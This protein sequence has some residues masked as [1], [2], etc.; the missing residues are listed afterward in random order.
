M[1]WAI[2][3]WVAVSDERLVLHAGGRGEADALHV[4]RQVRAA[5]PNDALRAPPRARPDAACWVVE[6]FVPR[7]VKV[8]PWPAGTAVMVLLGSLTAPAS[9]TS[10]R[11]VT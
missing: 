3:C 5:N 1:S 11:P 8:E 4:V 2:S 6:V 10:R 7:T 9:Q